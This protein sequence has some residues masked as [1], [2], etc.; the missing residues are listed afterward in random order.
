MEV[1]YCG[2]C[3]HM[4][5]L[6]KG[7]RGACRLNGCPCQGF[8]EAPAAPPAIAQ[9]EP[10]APGRQLAAVVLPPAVAFLAGLVLGIAG[11]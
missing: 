8:A 3:S 2:A 6:H 9:L 7:G 1:A 5:P 4:A 11:R 10:V